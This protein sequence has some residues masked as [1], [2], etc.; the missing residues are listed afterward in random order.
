MATP[1]CNNCVMS[2]RMTCTLWL[3]SFLLS[4]FPLQLCINWTGYLIC[5]RTQFLCN[6]HFLMWLLLQM[7]CLVI[8][9]FY[10]HNSGFPLSV[11]GSWSGSMCRAHIALQELQAVVMMLHR[12]AFQLPGRVVVLHLDNSTVKAYLCNQGGTVSPFSLDWPARYWVW[13]TSIV[14]HLFQHTFLPISMW[15][16]IICQR[17]SCFWND[18]FFLKLPKCLFTFEVYQR[19]ICWH[20]PIPL[21]VSIIIPWKFHYL[22]G[23]GIECLQSSLEVSDKLWLSSSCISSSSSV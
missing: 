12:L 15:R 2:F 8:W 13:L 7:P 18:I 1:N 19:W 20:P 17:V 4:T 5:N 6:F 9:A 11:S 10:F 14:V 22:W 3:N 21:N 23:L 16:L